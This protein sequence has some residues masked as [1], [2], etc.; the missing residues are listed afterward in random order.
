M[1]TLTIDDLVRIINQLQADIKLLQQKRMYQMDYTPQ[2]ITNRAMGEPNSYVFS[3]LSANRPTTG[4]A[5]KN[6]GLGCSIWWST[7]THVLSIWDGTVWRTV[8]L[9]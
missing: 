9:S 3:G 5:L 8:T 7:D 2:S 4:V 1:D 6:A